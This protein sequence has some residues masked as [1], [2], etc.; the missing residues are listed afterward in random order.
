MATS[1][2]AAV[3]ELILV[4]LLVGHGTF[5]IY[6]LALLLL[7]ASQSLWLRDASWRTLGLAREGVSP[8]CVLAAVAAAAA[9]LV[10]VRI[11]IAPFAVWVTGEPIDLSE[12]L[13]PGDGRALLIRLAQAWT[14]AAFGEEMVFRGYL[15]HRT[16]DLI[17]QTRL[18]WV[19]AIATSSTLFGLAH[20]YQGWGG[21]AAAA[22]VG[23]LLSVLYHFNQKNL[24]VVIICH[25]IVDTVGLVAIYSGRG[26]LVLPD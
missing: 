11:G 21:V 17:G 25:G 2:K 14:L 9:V 24:W 6:H 8:R 26:S 15:M 23:V 13:T 18:G 22:I 1:R 4:A 16:V 19:V 7:L 10:V 3:A 12:I 5:S 20:R